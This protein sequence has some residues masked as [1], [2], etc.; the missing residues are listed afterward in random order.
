MTDNKIKSL[1]VVEDNPGLQK[2][3]K[4]SLE[5]YQVFLADDRASAIR[6]LKQ[7]HMPVVTLDLGLP[8]DPDNA[9]EGLAALEEILN[10]APHTKIIVVTG[11][12]DR[13]NT[14]KAIEL[15][16]YDFYQKPIDP[17]ILVLI[18]DRA[19]NLY[20][21]ETEV[22]QL[23]E[24]KSASPLDGIVGSSAQILAACRM[25]EKV[26]PTEATT[27]ILG[28]SGTGKELI[29]RALHS[30]SP[31]SDQPFIALNCAAI[32]E[33]LLE[34]EL[35]GY[36]K[37][38]F[39]GAVKQTLGKIESANGGTFFFDEIGDM[40]MSLQ[41]KLLRF[42]QE[43]VIE[44][45]GG[46]TQIPIDVRIICATHRDLVHLIE[47]SEFRE[48]L[49]YRISEIV[50]EIPPLREREGDRLLLAQNFLDKFSQKNGR[51]FHGFTGQAS[52]QI[53]AYIWPGN[54]R[55]MENKVK[56]A[57]ILAEGKRITTGDLGFTEQYES[58][59]LSLQEAREQAEQQLIV[60]ALAIHNNN[61]SHVAEAMGISR[62]SLYK[63][64]KKLNMSEPDI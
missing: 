37:G 26:G 24:H 9:S 47:T 48:D 56:R 23:A 12:D 52:T 58:Q 31:R 54:V 4:W 17:D 29:A 20:E 21:L 30:L 38:A 62:P 3:L 49:Y 22:R 15:G 43:R 2:Q 57:V 35:F 32:P 13:K 6:Q 50:I 16:A 44:R 45:I 5:G 1:L 55:E 28:E 25:V 27:L 39:T 34:S 33:N 18:V 51:N 59:S 61:I 7:H 41:A 36:E 19:Y 8:P 53:D 63:L 64:L 11:N 46:R 40:P 10:L 42:I 14:L 60:R